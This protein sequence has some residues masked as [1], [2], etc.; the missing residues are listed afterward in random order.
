MKNNKE[1]HAPDKRKIRKILLILAA[2]ALAAAFLI[3]MMVYRINEGLVEQDATVEDVDVS[4]VSEKT[5]TGSYSSGH[6]Y[7]DVEVTVV[8][9]QYTDIQL[10]GYSGINPSRAAQVID[11]II[12]HQTL[13]PDEGDIGEQFT[14]II[15]Q[16]AIYY[17]I[18]Y[19]YSVG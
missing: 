1:K 7:A 6:M 14:D 18:R 4:G 10:T 17:A 16:K 8:N 12:R 11:A 9:G 19:N 13:T 2:S 5:F 15:V 3:P